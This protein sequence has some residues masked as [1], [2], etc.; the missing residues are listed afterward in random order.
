MD[1]TLQ[2]TALVHEAYLKLVDQS[3]VDWRDR[4][5]FFAVA[6]T[7]MRR[8]LV[9]RARA[10]GRLRRGGG[11]R[12]RVPLDAARDA[13]APVLE[14]ESPVDLIDLDEAL[15]AFGAAHP[16]EARLVELRFFAGL[17]LPEAAESLGISTRTAERWWAFSRAWLLRTLNGPNAESGHG[18]E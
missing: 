6:A 15:V 8:I 13:A 18:T 11:K 17:D 16:D 2:A 7:A 12:A 10:R 9:D 5:H 3:R 14:T 1:Q 4:T